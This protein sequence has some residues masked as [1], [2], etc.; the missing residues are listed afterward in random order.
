MEHSDSSAHLPEEAVLNG[1]AGMPV[2]AGKNLGDIF[3]RPGVSIAVVPTFPSG[4]GDPAHPHY[5]PN[6]DGPLEE[7]SQGARFL[8]VS[9]GV[10]RLILPQ[11]AHL[12]QLHARIYETYGREYAVPPGHPAIEY[13]G[14]RHGYARVVAE[15]R[16]TRKDVRVVVQH[17]FI[18]PRI[19]NAAYYVDPRTLVDLNDKAK[20]RELTDALP[21]HRPVLS[22]DGDFLAAMHENGFPEGVKCVV[23]GAFG[24][25]GDTVFVIDPTDRNDRRCWNEK[26]LDAAAELRR[27]GLTSVIAERFFEHS[28]SYNVQVA[29]DPDGRL[30]HLHASQQQLSAGGAYQGNRIRLRSLPEETPAEVRAIAYEIAERAAERGLRGGMIGADVMH[31]PG[32]DGPGVAIAAENNGR[33]NGSTPWKLLRNRIAEYSGKELLRGVSVTPSAE[34]SFPVRTVNDMLARIRKKLDDGSVF[35]LGGAEIPSHNPPFRVYAGIV[36]NDDAEI[37]ST[38]LSLEQD[39]LRV[40]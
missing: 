8:P 25:G 4:D 11:S 6:I 1:Y 9:A 22:L 36:G 34:S 38:L 30:S 15:L 33:L 2:F 17:P 3:R 31:R 14:D 24:A 35:L 40:K 21:A 27:L 39:G 10:E 18:D 37:R 19:E 29:I 12:P 5:F 32:T 23:K 16:R 28:D 20:L 7:A 13:Y 26:V